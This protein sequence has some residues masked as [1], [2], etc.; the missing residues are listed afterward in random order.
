MVPKGKLVQREFKG[1]QEK[2]VLEVQRARLV[3]RG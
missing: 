1:K 2:P 3:L